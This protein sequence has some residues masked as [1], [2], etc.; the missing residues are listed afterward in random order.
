MQLSVNSLLEELQR[1]ILVLDGAMGTMIRRLRPGDHCNNDILCLTHPD[2]IYEIHRLY[3]EA[4]ADIISTNSFNAN[5]ISQADYQTEGL[6]RDINAAAVDIAHRA[7]YDAMARRPGRKIWVAGSIGPTNRMASISPDINDPAFR[8]VKYDQ[9]FDV[10]REQID[11][12]VGGG[13]DIL[14]FETVFD[15]LNLKAGLDAVQ[16]VFEVRGQAL[17]VMVSATIS[18]ESGRI[19][20][21]QTIEALWASIAGYDCIVSFG[22][23]CSWGAQHMRPYIAEAAQVADVF[24]SCHPSAGLPDESGCYDDADLFAAHVA[25]FMHDGSVNIVG[26]CCGTTPGHIAALS[27]TVRQYSPHR[28]IKHR[29]STR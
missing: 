5:A 13:C 28:P 15:A 19:L 29:D 22:L 4:G 9:L 10:Y 17:P 23:N 16:H 12:L 2:D 11:A 27:K 18:M 21:G 25:E 24:I 20:S 14:L 7:A 8:N 6:V 3:I 26:G 1:R